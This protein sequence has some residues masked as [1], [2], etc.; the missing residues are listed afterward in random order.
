MKNHSLYI[1]S[2]W[3][4]GNAE[5]ILIY[6]SASN[7]LIWQGNAADKE[8]VHQAFL[9]AQQ[10]FP[11]WSKQELN[12]RIALLQSYGTELQKRKKAIALTI[13]Q[14]M[15]KLLHESENEVDTMIKKIAISIEAYSQRCPEKQQTLATSTVVTRYKP[16]GVMAILGPFNFPGHLPNGHLVPALLAGNT[17]VFKPSELTPLTALQMM[18][19][20]EAAGFPPGVVNCVNGGKEVAQALL[21]ESINGVLFTGSYATGQAIHREFAGKPEVMLA[22][23]MGGN[24]PLVLFDTNDH[25]KT[26]ENIIQSAFVTSGQRC[27]CARRLIIVRNKNNEKILEALIKKAQQLRL[28]SYLTQPSAFIGPVVSQPAADKILQQYQNLLKCGAKVLL[29][30]MQD[31]TNRKLLSPGIL[32]VTNVSVPDEEIFGPLL[33]VV[34]VDDV[35]S[36]I[37]AANNT[38][39]GLVA[40]C[41]TDHP[42]MFQQFYQEVHAG[43]I[44]WN[45]SLTGASSNAPFGG[46]GHSGNHRP[47]AFYAADYCAYPVASMISR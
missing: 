1:N 31:K 24:N 29:K 10:A 15:G 11:A 44:N 45:C 42:E 36:A 19:C 35:T 46:V 39:Y 8:Q 27:T 20:Y 4:E 32:D 12:A 43:I 2:K 14:E 6:D 28:G 38:V 30:L 18:E 3:Q 40:G 21:A 26:L 33:Q 16:L 22:L 5:P 9:A 37:A 25:E 23:E 17:I 47:S 34:W 7:E 41:I 13:S